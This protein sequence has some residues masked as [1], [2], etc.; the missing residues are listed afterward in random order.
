MVSVCLSSRIM[1]SAQ[2]IDPINAINDGILSLL[3]KLQPD[4]YICI[5]IGNENYVM[6]NDCQSNLMS[7]QKAKSLFKEIKA[8]IQS[9]DSHKNKKNFFNQGI[10]E[11]GQN[12]D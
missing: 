6:E 10:Y 5:N 8:Y 3:S 4:D 7:W 11:V 2:T 9:R 12:S 1:Q